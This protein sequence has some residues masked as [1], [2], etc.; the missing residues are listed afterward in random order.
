MN[1]DEFLLDL[2][3][4]QA[5]RGLID[6]VERA[7]SHAPEAISLAADPT[8]AALVVFGVFLGLARGHFLIAV[9]GIVTVMGL[10]EHLGLVTAPAYFDQLVALGLLAGTLHLLLVAFLGPEGGGS[11]FA[12]LIVSAALLALLL[13]ARSLRAFARMAKAIVGKGVGK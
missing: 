5:L 11:S 1:M 2:F 7:L 10:A 8:N 12:S 4:A 9:A 6:D 13:P 3:D